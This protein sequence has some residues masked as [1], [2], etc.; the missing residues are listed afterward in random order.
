[1][2]RSLYHYLKRVARQS[3]AGWD[4]FWFAPKCA[5]NIGFARISLGTIA[6]IYAA[7]WISDLH[8]WIG[9][10]G[11][12][13]VEVTRYLIGDGLAGTGS[14]GRLS[15]LYG[16]ES[17]LWIRIYL[18]VTMLSSIAMVLGLG[19]RLAAMLSW[20]LTLGIIHRIPM[21]QGAGELLF[22]GIMGYLI[23]DP[24]KVRCWSRIGFA[25]QQ[26]RWTASLSLRLMQ[27]HVVVWF[28]ISILSHF[29][30]PMWWSGTATWWLAIGQR[31]PWLSQ[32]F[33][34]DK[35]YLMNV[36]SHGF[37][38]IHLVA[39]I[40]LVCKGCRLLAIGACLLMAMSVWIL[41]GDWM[42]GL[43][44]VGSTACFWG[45]AIKEL[46]IVPFDGKEV[47]AS[48]PSQEFRYHLSPRAE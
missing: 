48:V 24:G 12:L 26:S 38:A 29:A 32:D 3:I 33:L 39:L 45:T 41:A 1:M 35:P 21:L 17:A 8:T 36:F 23:I 25:D 16:I 14:A 22:T 46:G 2:I 28:A 13:N 37:L 19:G 6:A 27:C 7:S 11:R 44:L 43:A 9:N 47:E 34:S 20:V 18:V 4:K 30:E 15:P 5:T 10:E 42:Y 40:L 31:S